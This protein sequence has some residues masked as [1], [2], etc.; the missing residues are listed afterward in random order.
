MS[1]HPLSRQ[2]DGQSPVSRSGLSADIE[3]Y[4]LPVYRTAA[5]VQSDDLG[6]C[7]AFILSPGDGVGK[8]FFY[9]ST[10]N[11]AHNGSSIIVDAGGRRYVVVEGNY[12]NGGDLILDADGDSYLHETSDDTITLV[13]GGND[14]ARFTGSDLYLTQDNFTGF[15]RIGSVSWRSY[16]NGRVGS[17]NALMDFSPVP[18]DGTSNAIVRFFRDTNTAGSSYCDFNVGDGSATVNHRIAAS[19]GHTYFCAQS[20]NV[21][22][23]T[24]SPSTM[25]HANGP[26]RHATYTVATLPSAS[27]VGAGTR[28][29]V[30]DANATTF[31]A[32]VAGSGANTVPVFS[33]GT[34]WRIG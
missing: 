16:W 9:K 17:G 26:I 27:T 5:E 7:T 4:S 12:L 14:R 1:T 23:G 19:G 8:L 18:G 31:H 3:R 34:N 29:M 25:V 30:T 24:A 2:I 32:I 22:I 20:G 28:A 15:T 13:L 6:E 11:G 10:E 33:D 21:G